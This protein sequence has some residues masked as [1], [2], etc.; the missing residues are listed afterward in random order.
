[1][2]GMN[3]AEKLRELAA[4]YHEF[5]ERAENHAI[6]NARLRLAEDLERE[7]ACLEN[8]HGRRVGDRTGSSKARSRHLVPT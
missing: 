4:W 6:W 1:M 5:A 7:A 3:Q 2:S 8:R